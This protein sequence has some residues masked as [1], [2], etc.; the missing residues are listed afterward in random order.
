MKARGRDPRPAQ[1]LATT[2]AVAAGASIETTLLPFRLVQLLATYSRL[3]IRVALSPKAEQFVSVFALDGLL[4]DFVYTE[5][6]SYRPRTTIPF[7]LDFGTSDL[8]VLFPATARIVAECALGL[9]TCP[10]TR[11]FAFKAKEQIIVVPHLHPAMDVSLYVDHLVR[12]ERVGA[13]V[14][15]PSAGLIWK[16]ESAWSR[17]LSVIFERL[18]L[19]PQAKPTSSY[20]IAYRNQLPDAN[21]TDSG[22]NEWVVTR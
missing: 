2:L 21:G 8:L 18:K 4:D 17:A 10:V 16:D 14:I 5:S 1:P 12:I 7:H 19:D 15:R 9:I 22:P 3:K 11:L 13:T 6:R 20:E